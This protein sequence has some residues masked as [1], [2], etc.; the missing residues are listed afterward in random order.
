MKQFIAIYKTTGEIV[1]V[2][3]G[4]LCS[5]VEFYADGKVFQYLMAELGGASN[6]EFVADL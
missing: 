5:L 4:P 3:Q 6:F 1:L 2:H